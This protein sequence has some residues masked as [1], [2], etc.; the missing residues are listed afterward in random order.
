MHAPST[1]ACDLDACVRPR[2]VRA[3]S[4]RHA[5]SLAHGIAADSACGSSLACSADPFFINEAAYYEKGVAFMVGHRSEQPVH[6]LTN[7]SGSKRQKTSA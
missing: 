5:A 2:R 4:L 7:A 6:V 1:R 3:P